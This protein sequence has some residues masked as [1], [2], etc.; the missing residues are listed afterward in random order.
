MRQIRQM[1]VARGARVGQNGSRAEPNLKVFL[2]QSTMD[3]QYPFTLALIAVAGS[4]V[5]WQFT[6][7]VRSAWS[8]K[9]CG[10]GCG[11]CKPEAKAPEPGRLGLPLVKN[12]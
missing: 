1:G 9:G 5:L 10:S 8:G 7:V 6:K 2:G 3:W 4:A 11:R 12:D